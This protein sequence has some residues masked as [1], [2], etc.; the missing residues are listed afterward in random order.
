MIKRVGIDDANLFVL[1]PFPGTPLYEK[2]KKEG[3]LLPDRAG[4][5]F[6]WSRAIYQ[7]KQM[8]PEELEQGVQWAYD[9]LYPHFRRKLK[10]VLWNQRSRLLFNLRFAWGVVEGNLRHSRV[11]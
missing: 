9:Q 11:G 4:M 6:A 7:P 3:R 2:Y 5:D 8:T 10:W 1:T